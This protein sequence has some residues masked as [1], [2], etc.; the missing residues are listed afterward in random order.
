MESMESPLRDEIPKPPFWLCIVCVP[1]LVWMKSARNF[2][3]VGV[4]SSACFPV[5]FY[6]SAAS[7]SILSRSVYPLIRHSVLSF[8]LFPPLSLCFVSLCL[9]VCCCVSLLSVALFL[10][11]FSFVSCLLAPSGG[12]LASG[13]LSV[14]ILSIHRWRATRRQRKTQGML[15]CTNA[16]RRS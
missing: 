7:L 2:I 13:L 6:V 1:P 14:F 11:L 15:Y 12:R 3:P 10:R 4:L 9:P 8:C 16:C 5:F